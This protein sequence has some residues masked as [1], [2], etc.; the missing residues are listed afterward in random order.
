MI[1]INFIH[2]GKYTKNVYNVKK[3]NQS[4]MINCGKRY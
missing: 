3:N 4:D 2:L 1:I